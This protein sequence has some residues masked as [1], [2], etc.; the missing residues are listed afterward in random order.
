MGTHSSFKTRQCNSPS[1]TCCPRS[2]AV[3]QN[4]ESSEAIRVPR[5]VFNGTFAGHPQETC[6]KTA[7]QAAG[8]QRAGWCTPGEIASDPPGN[9]RAAHQ[10]N[11]AWGVVVSRACLVANGGP[12]RYWD[13]REINILTLTKLKVKFKSRDWLKTL[14]SMMSLLF[15]YYFHAVTWNYEHN[16]K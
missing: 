5:P 15:E 2:P 4:H 11:E 9:H 13:F 14:L 10:Q 3:L 1:C 16:S 6:P 8:H 7:S 12:T